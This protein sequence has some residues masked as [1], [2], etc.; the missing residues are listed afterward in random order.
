MNIIKT[1]IA[2]SALLF[3]FP[4]VS[5]AADEQLNPWTE[6]GI[7]A[8]I[9]SS[10]PW[11]AAISNVIW[12]LG[13][14]AFTSAG[15]SKHTCEGKEVVA[16]L[17]INETYA[18]LEEETIKGNGQHISAVLNIMGCDSTAHAGIVS[19]MRSEL[20]NSM[21][22]SAYIE[23]NRQEKAQNYYQILQKQVTGAHTQQC[24]TV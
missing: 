2:A 1:A 3:A 7:G 6:C 22:N 20:G 13:T 21:L 14:T 12:D 18:N 4:S 15:V 9:F 24:Q 17:F 8:M 10:T 23:K 5:V 16:A 19:A 11:A